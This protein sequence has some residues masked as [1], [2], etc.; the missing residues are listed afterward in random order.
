MDTAPSEPAGESVVLR[1]R[2]TM[3]QIEERGAWATPS[4]RRR[5]VCPTGT[6]KW[7]QQ[8]EST[9]HNKLVFVGWLLLWICGVWQRNEQR[10][11]SLGHSYSTRPL[12]R[13]PSLK[14]SVPSSTLADNYTST[15][16]QANIASYSTSFALASPAHKYMYHTGLSVYSRLH[17]SALIGI[18]GRVFFIYVYTRKTVPRVKTSTLTLQIHYKC[19]YKN[20]L[21]VCEISS[22]LECMRVYKSL[23][24]KSGWK[25][26]N[27]QV[28]KM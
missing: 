9:V 8:T 21:N 28:N 6:R 24:Q 25:D 7:L 5:S 16:P 26:K 1:E 12:K 18:Q 17:V 27:W 14:L 10:E 19:T 4:G 22:A 2:N 13:L 20:F 23:I 3:V 15:A 11:R